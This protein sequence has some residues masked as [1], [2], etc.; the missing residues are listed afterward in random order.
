MLIPLHNI[1]DP[2]IPNVEIEISWS[3]FTSVTCQGNV[4]SHDHFCDNLR[5]PDH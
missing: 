2:Q 5:L 3:L 1:W 4:S